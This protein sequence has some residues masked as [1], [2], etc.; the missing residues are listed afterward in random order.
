MPAEISEATADRAKNARA[1]LRFVGVEVEDDRDQEDQALHRAHP[2]AG[3]AGGD[4]ARLDHADD[5]AAEHRADDRRPAAEDRGA[6][7]QHRGDRGQ[8]VALALIAEEVLVLERQ[9]DR[10][11]GGEKAHQR[12]ELDLLAIDVDADD[13]RDFV[14][15]ADEQRVLAEAVAGENEPEKDD[16]D[17]RPQRLHRQLLQPGR[18]SMPANG[19]PTIH[20]H[21]EL[22]S[23][24]RSA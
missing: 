22:S 23:A 17:R 15:I 10:G 2:G 6:A 16:D 19:R 13:A 8:Q 1:A 11:A 21:T 9:H 20:C 5:E 14:R 3:Q 18:R 7:D 24:P 4:Q 12:E